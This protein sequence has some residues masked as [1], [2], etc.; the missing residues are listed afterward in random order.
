MPYVNLQITRGATR[1]QK[2]R[3]VAEFSATLAN[4]LGKKPEHTHI[5]SR[6]S[7]R[8]TGGM[9]AC[10]PTTGKD[11]KAD[12]HQ[13]QYINR[14]GPVPASL[15]PSLDGNGLFRGKETS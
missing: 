7:T 9:P 5:S 15:P 13:S 6:K 10:S 3:I 8:K 1:E 12:A 4:V 14:F 2:A 11:I